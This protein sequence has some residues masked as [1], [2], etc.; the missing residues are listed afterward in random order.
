[1]FF[2]FIID[3]RVGKQKIPYFFTYKPRRW[4]AGSFRY[5]QAAQKKK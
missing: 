5:T 1:M 3:Q 4:K 2:K